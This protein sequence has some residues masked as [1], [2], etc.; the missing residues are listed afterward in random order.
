MSDAGD[1]IG[2]GHQERSR[3]LEADAFHGAVGANEQS[4]E[5]LPLDQ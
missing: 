4:P 3:F 1:V 2:P 5:D